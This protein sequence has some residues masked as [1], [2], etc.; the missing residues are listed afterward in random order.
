M[1]TLLEVTDLSVGYTRPVVGPISFR[2]EPGEVV[3]LQGPN[4]A[5]KST[6]LRAL[7]GMATIFAGHISRRPGL[8]I[9]YQ[10]QELPQLGE[11]PISGQ[12]VLRSAAAR[13]DH[14]P[15]S[16]AQLLHQRI[17]RM[18]S[19]EK[20]QLL[21]WAVLNCGADLAILD[22]PTNNLDP[23][24]VSWVGEAIRAPTDDRSA[25][26]VSHDAAF[27]DQ[28]CTRVVRVGE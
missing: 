6:L 24:A 9:S 7:A 20:Q 26:V 19:G 27:G 1:N 17:D 23:A 14:A 12:D 2:V 8:L 21:I 22:E 13:Q 18:S 10:S 28:V 15:P 4:G 11:M 25:I 5:G 3:G 16:V